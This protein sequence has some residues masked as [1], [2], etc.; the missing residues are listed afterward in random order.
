M[1]V[2]FVVGGIGPTA[3]GAPLAVR[4]PGARPVRARA[5]TALVDAT[6]L[7]TVAATTVVPVATTPTWVNMGVL[8]VGTVRAVATTPTKA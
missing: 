7:P 1:P 8:G 6:A 3:A 2:F 4:R 5:T